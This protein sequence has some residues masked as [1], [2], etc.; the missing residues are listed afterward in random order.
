M[1]E[2]KKTITV[3]E[4]VKELVFD[5]M[6]KSYLTG[7]THE[8]AGLD[9][10][11]ASYMQASEDSDNI[12]Q[13]KRSLTNYFSTLKS[14]L[15]EYL[16]EDNTTSDNTISQEIENDGELTLSFKLPS[17]YNNASA[18]ALGNGIH[19]YLTDMALY[20]WFIITNKQDAQEYLTHADA[21]LNAVKRALYK[22]IRPNRPTYN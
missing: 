12:Y 10:K 15:G 3:T 14:T 20:D 18:D 7:Q 4:K 16:D 5:I 22:R 8:A 6:N 21:C 13:I 2:N 17:N 11:A 9:Y 1:A 19:S